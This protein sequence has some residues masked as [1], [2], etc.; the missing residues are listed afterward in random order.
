[1]M[2]QPI[3]NTTDPWRHDV[4]IASDTHDCVAWLQDSRLDEGDLLIE[5]DPAADDAWLA[6]TE[7][8]D[9]RSWR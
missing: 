8:L 6:S 4:A 3:L 2:H 7:P 1:M 9:L 5:Y